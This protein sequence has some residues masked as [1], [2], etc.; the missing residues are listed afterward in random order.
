[1]ARGNKKGFIPE[2]VKPHQWKKGQSG[3]PAGGKPLVRQFSATARE[4]LS[5]NEISVTW[6][7]AGKVKSLNVKS[8]QNFH[9]GIVAAMIMESLKGNIRAAE[10]L[11]DRT[12]GKP[13]Q[14]IEQMNIEAPA[15]S[16]FAGMTT[17]ELRKALHDIRE[18]PEKPARKRAN[19]GAGKKKPS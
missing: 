8:D 5:A 15:Q 18:E 10:M 3:N 12:E 19:A 13:V 14:T 2:A 6:N 7:V 9:H 4:M 11:I 16:P 17:D 1:M